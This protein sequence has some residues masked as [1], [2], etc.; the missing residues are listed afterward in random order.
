MAENQV[1]LVISAV[2]DTRRA[3]ESINKHLNSL[4]TQAAIAAAKF[5]VIKKAIEEV[6]ELLAK[7]FKPAYEAV[8]AY[9]QSVIRMAGFLTSMIAAQSKVD[10]AKTYKDATQYARWLVEELEKIDAKTIASAEHLMMMA[11]EMAKQGVFLKNNV[12]ELEAFA[13]IANAV[14]IIAE[15][16][17]AKE[18]QIRQEIRALLQGQVDAHSQLASILNSMVGGAL[19]EQVQRWKES[20]EWV[21]RVGELLSGFGYASKDLEMTWSAI[22]STFKTLRN[23]ILRLGFT[24]AY[25]QINAFLRSIIDF[26]RENEELLGTIYRRGWLAIKGIIET[27]YN[28]LRGFSPVLSS[29]LK[30]IGLIANGLGMI[31]YVILP[32]VAERIG[33][34]LSGMVEWLKLTGRLVEL[35]YRL[36]TFDFKGVIRAKE[37]IKESFEKAGEY[38]GKAFAPGLSDEFLRR[39]EDWTKRT[40]REPLALGDIFKKLGAI[41][42]AAE[43][44]SKESLERLQESYEEFLASLEAER[45]KGLNKEL[46]QIEKWEI[47]KLNKLKEYRRKGVISEREFKE[48]ETLIHEIA[49]AKKVEVIREYQKRKEQLEKQL[50]ENLL[51]EHEAR[52]KQI[53]EKERE[54]LERLE[55]LYEGRAVSFKEYE[56]LKT[57]IHEAALKERERAEKEYHYRLEEARINLELARIRTEEK[58]KEIAREEALRREIEALNE[59]ISL[60]EEQAEWLRKLGEEEK[61]LALLEDIESLKEKIAGLNEELRTLTGTFREGILEALREYSEA[62]KNKF[63]QGKNFAETLINSMEDAFM[64]FLDVTSSKFLDW[65]ALILSIL[66]AIYRELLKILVIQPLVQAI[67]GG[68]MKIIPIHSGGLIMHAGGVVPRFH[69]GVDEVPAILQVGERVLS[70]EQNRIFEKLARL[71]DGINEPPREE[72]IQIVNVIDPGLLQQYL[73]SQAGQRA[74]V[75]VIGMNANMVRKILVGVR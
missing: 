22:S 46:L 67:T 42:G 13:N 32:P 16:S 50:T 4:S 17:G 69:L 19:K 23:Q 3:F 62:L 21:E 65:K 5:V 35:F 49:E 26:L 28:I 11:E 68:I 30:L 12:R 48:K 31:A 29:V 71:I 18:V 63:E 43:K 1:K 73:S 9:N 37:A 7:T 54:A 56:D 60:Y 45:E 2:D 47:D 66:Q 15:G 38:T 33:Y 75:N 58:S 41:G 44:A 34:I 10:L 8:E 59:L 55:E 39:Y 53:E 6:G 40:V 36:T 14:A 74:I 51:T 52:L 20:G 27:V 64:N 57:K 61:W 70:R 24:E 25:Y 72:A